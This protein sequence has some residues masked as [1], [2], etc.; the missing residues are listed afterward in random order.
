MSTFSTLSELYESISKEI[1]SSLLHQ[2]DRNTASKLLGRDWYRGD[3]DSL[4]QAVK[5]VAEDY[6]KAMTRSEQIALSMNCDTRLVRE[7]SDKQT[8][9]FY[10]EVN[11]WANVGDPYA[12]DREAAASLLC[13]AFQNSTQEE[14]DL[15]HYDLKSLP[16]VFDALR[17]IKTV[18]LSNNELKDLPRSFCRMTELQILNLESNAL[19]SLPNEFGQL[20]GLRKLN[21][22]NNDLESLPDNFGNLASLKRL[23][24]RH[25]KL[26]DLPNSMDQLTSL[27]HLSLGSN[28]LSVTPGIIG[29]I[30]TLEFLDLSNNSIELFNLFF[31]GLLLLRHLNLSRNSIS[32]LSDIFSVNFRALTELN[33]SNN[34][35]NTLPESI[36]ALPGTCTV[37]IENNSAINDVAIDRLRERVHAPNYSG[38][39]FVYSMSH[40]ATFSD[41]TLDENMNYLA[42][43]AEQEAPNVQVFDENLQEGLNA[44]FNRLSD[45]KVFQNELTRK[46]LSASILDSCRLATLD[47]EYRRNVFEPVLAQA[48]ETCGDR[49]AL[50]IIY[51]EIN[52]KIATC[53]RHNPQEMARLLVNGAWTLALLETAAQQIIKTQTLVDPVETLL[54]FPVKLRDELQIP[55]SINLMLFFRCS[56]VDKHH[57]AEAVTYVRAHTNNEEARLDFLIMQNAWLECLEAAD[58][59]RL[60]A[61]KNERDENAALC[62]KMQEFT[63]V[64]IQYK[65]KLRVFSKSVLETGPRLHH[66]RIRRG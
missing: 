19:A 28:E 42:G 3:M 12:E 49:V 9:K 11:S 43:I 53:D 61:I 48:S 58:S 1:S 15:S 32:E 20:R 4:A 18:D 17:H 50:A 51:L 7:I 62:T 5:E 38:P 6:F 54:A 33:L 47:A 66:P 26:R 57:L 16:D 29:R 55:H 63:A 56:G 44:F 10:D 46:E 59:S 24:L 65:Q 13:E 39:I 27:T 22:K 25:N 31:G 60:Q 23:S 14:L 64:E 52:Q 2:L 36:F 40:T 41:R 34:S 35:L 37:T 30:F 21:L 45:V 8:Q